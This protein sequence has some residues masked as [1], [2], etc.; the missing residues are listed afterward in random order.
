MTSLPHPRASRIGHRFPD[1]R[2]RPP[3]QLDLSPPIVI[4][5]AT[6]RCCPC[7]YTPLGERLTVA[8]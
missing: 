8:A 3:A 4:P 6:R 5:K 7:D 1:L 2:R